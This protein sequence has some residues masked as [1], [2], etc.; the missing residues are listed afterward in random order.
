[1]IN[2]IVGQDNRL[3]R[4][5]VV[6]AKNEGKKEK[7]GAYVLFRIREQAYVGGRAP[8]TCVRFDVSTLRSGR[9]T[10]TCGIKDVDCYRRLVASEHVYI[11]EP[12]EYS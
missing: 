1:M 4:A 11:S 3:G 8:A 12:C 2:Q 9:T 10:T 6:F 7:K 5:P